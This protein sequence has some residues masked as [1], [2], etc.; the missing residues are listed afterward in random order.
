ME[1]YRFSFRYAP[2]LQGREAAEC[3]CPIGRREVYGYR[4]RNDEDRTAN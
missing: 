3:N 2:V 4:S 1:K